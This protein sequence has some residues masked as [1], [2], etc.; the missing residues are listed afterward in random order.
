[1]FNQF[2]TGVT[3]SLTNSSLSVSESNSGTTVSLC[4]SLDGVPGPIDRD[5]EVTL[6]TVPGTAG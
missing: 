6:N 2:L 4:V 1:M 3:V 5:I